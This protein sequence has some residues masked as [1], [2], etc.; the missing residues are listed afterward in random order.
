[1][2]PRVLK[3]CFTRILTA[4]LCIWVFAA[5]CAVSTAVAA[6]KDDSLHP[7]LAQESSNRRQI[8]DNTQPSG[9]NLSEE[10]LD[11]LYGEAEEEAIH[12]A[13]PLAPWNIAMFHFNDKFYFWVLKPVARGY[14]AVMPGKVRGWVK[15]FF[16]NIRAP[17]RFVN[18]TLQG[19]WNAAGGEL[20][21]FV[22]NTTV[23]I[24][25]FGNPAKDDPRLNPSEEDLGQTFGAYGAGNGFYIVWPF[26]GPST[27]RDTLGLVGDRFLYPVAYVEPFEAAIAIDGYG[28]L[29][30]TS[31]R[32]GDYE[33]LKEAFLD[34][35]AAIRD[36]YIQNRRKKVAE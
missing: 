20:A 31:F 3:K 17:V 32:I 36:A 13:D 5:N 12:I 22:V 35:Y 16:Y 33:A 2:N 34:P 29:N 26:I 7:V 10:E 6:E 28:I 23:G 25:G 8:Q 30:E 1:M 9:K 19:K 14:R 21:R 15:N 27:L 24:L 18:C 4:T 11:F